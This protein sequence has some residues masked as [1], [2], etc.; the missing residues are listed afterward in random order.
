MHV[1]HCFHAPR[2]KC[3]NSWCIFSNYGYVFTDLSES[4]TVI[5]LSKD[6]LDRISFTQSLHQCI[7]VTLALR[8][9]EKCPTTEFLSV[10]ISLYSHCINLYVYYVNLC[11]QSEHRKTRPRKNSA[12]GHFSWNVVKFTPRICCSI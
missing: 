4:F 8:L 3:F 1:S 2:S 10:R 7:T 6:R 11:I 12:L 9:H 5:I